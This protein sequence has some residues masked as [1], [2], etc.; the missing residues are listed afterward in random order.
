MLS[1][2]DDVELLLLFYLKI[3]SWILNHC[4]ASPTALLLTPVYPV[5]L[6]TNLKRLGPK[7][8]ELSNSEL[9]L[10]G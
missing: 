9:A 5:S 8:V 3:S 6:S 10:Y 2:C 1:M 4:Q 7:L